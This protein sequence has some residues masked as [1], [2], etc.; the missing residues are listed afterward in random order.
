MKI[1]V[2]LPD[3]NDIINLIVLLLK[4][5]EDEIFKKINKNDFDF[6]LKRLKLFK[7]DV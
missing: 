3:N 5:G 7:V 6:I 4:K 1:A 2:I